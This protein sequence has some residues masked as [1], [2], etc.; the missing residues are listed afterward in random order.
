MTAHHAST[1]GGILPPARGPGHLF[2]QM[3]VRMKNSSMNTAPNGRM[4]PIMI[5]K[6]PQPCLPEGRSPASTNISPP[7]QPTPPPPL[8]G[9][10]SPPLVSPPPHQPD[11]PL[12][13]PRQSRAKKKRR[14]TGVWVGA[15][16]PSEQ[17][18]FRTRM[19]QDWARVKKKQPTCRPGGDGP[20]RG[21][22]PGRGPACTR[23]A[24]GCAAGS[25]WGLRLP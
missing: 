7:W 12:F 2:S 21:Q 24:R 23:A 14:R 25:G 3:E 9:G 5:V 8:P 22:G 17:T 19:W 6:G 16:K 11:G 18:P 20:G 13:H 4:P 15:N 1:G 10:S